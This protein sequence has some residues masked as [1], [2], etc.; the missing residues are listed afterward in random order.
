MTS[1]WM[2]ANLGKSIPKAKDF[3]VMLM[4]LAR[5]TKK[6]Q[7]GLYQY[8]QEGWC[9]PTSFS[10]CTLPVFISVT[11]KTRLGYD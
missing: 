4:T 10:V 5:E 2:K 1:L 6:V 11:V 7:V 3:G 8:G 9:S